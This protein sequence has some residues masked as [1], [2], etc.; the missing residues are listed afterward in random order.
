MT[1]QAVAATLS[2]SSLLDAFETW[3]GAIRPAPKAPA[4]NSAATLQQFI[5]ALSPGRSA[6]KT[7]TS[8]KMVVSTNPP[9]KPFVPR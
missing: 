9:R 4:A 5:D 1:V 7:P 8:Q 6:S 3:V 2:G